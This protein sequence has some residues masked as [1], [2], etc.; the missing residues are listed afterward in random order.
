MNYKE[1]DELQRLF[2]NLNRRTSV[3]AEICFSAIAVTQGTLVSD[4]I[5]LKKKEKQ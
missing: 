1:V 5:R 4:Q 3:Q 2:F